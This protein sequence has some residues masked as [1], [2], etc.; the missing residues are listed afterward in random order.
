MKVEMYKVNLF[1]SNHYVI[2]EFMAHVHMNNATKMN[3]ISFII[4]NK[5]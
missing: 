5:H 4:Q 3:Q 1:K 2:K